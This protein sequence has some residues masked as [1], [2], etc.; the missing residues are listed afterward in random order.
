MSFGFNPCM[1][2][3]PEF[4]KEVKRDF[5]VHANCYDCKRFI[6]GCKGWAATKKF[7]CGKAKW[8]KTV[9]AK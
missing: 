4:G 2:H 8:Y 1:R 7:Q 5:Q 3:F 6:N 9:M